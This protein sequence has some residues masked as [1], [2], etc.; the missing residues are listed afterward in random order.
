LQPVDPGRSKSFIPPAFLAGPTLDKH[1]VAVLPFVN[2]SPDPQDEF[3]ADGLTEE[4]IDRLCQIRELEVIARTSVMSYKKKEKKAADIGRELKAGALVE[5]SVRK[6]G[7]KIRVT[8]QLVDANTEGHLWSSRYDRNLEDIFAVQT[9]IAEQVADALKVQL[10]PNEKKAI[11]KE[12]TTSKEAYRLYL[13]GR[14]YWNRRSPK[15]L[16]VAAEYFEKAISEDPS[17]ALAY[18]G[19]ADSYF[20]LMHGVH[21]VIKPSVEAAQKTRSWVEK[22]LELDASLAEAH[23][24]LGNILMWGFWDWRSAELEFKRS[25]ELNPSYPFARQWYGM[26]LSFTER[27]D[28]A[29]EQLRKALELDPFSPIIKLNYGAGLVEAGR[30]QEGIEQMTKTLALEPGFALGHNMLSLLYVHGS[31]LEKAETEL[32]KALDIIPGSPVN[33]AGLGRVYGLMGRKEDAAKILSELKEA[34]SRSY[35]SPALIAIV[36][37]GLGQR[38]DAFRHFEEAYNER[39]DFLLY[40]K[41]WPGFEDIRADERF[42][43]LLTKMG[44]DEHLSV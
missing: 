38:E 1:R 31:E 30:Y 41:T 27:L 5:G 11:Q 33:L 40:Y 25:I 26:Y 37:F 43:R 21:G 13:K 4:L 9:D 18:V 16:K 7:N 42:T 34:S 17:F 29:L 3:F 36:E 39:S 10:L 20:L 15:S 28:E 14:Y 19:L 32:K 23:A 24:T 8:A 44:F 12:P 22:A 6:A 2:L 35:V